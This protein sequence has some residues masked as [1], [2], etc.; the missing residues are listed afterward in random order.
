M[1]GLW[2]ADDGLGWKVDFPY[3]LVGI[4]AL[5]V[6]NLGRLPAYLRY[7]MP[8]DAPPREKFHR[9]GEEEEESPPVTGDEEEA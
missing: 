1:T 9:R 2:L 6:Y 5:I 7:F 8:G 3:L 4:G